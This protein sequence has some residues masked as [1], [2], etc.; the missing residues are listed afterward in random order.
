MR[1]LNSHL[2]LVWIR[3]FW[4]GKVGP[5]SETQKL[6]Q[7]K[8]T[9]K[10]FPSSPLNNWLVPRKGWSSEADALLLV[11][12]KLVCLWTLLQQTWSEDSRA[13]RLRFWDESPQSKY[14]MCHHRPGKKGGE[15]SHAAALCYLTANAAWNLLKAD[16]NRFIHRWNATDLSSQPL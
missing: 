13:G 9:R 12:G 15:G 7:K 10:Y 4:N 11:L 3:G 16:W 1:P 6:L 14:S 8:V 5:F 2:A